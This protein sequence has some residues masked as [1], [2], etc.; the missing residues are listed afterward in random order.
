MQFCLDPVG[1][2]EGVISFSF[3]LL[4][5]FVTCLAWTELST[6]A[7]VIERVH[8]LAKGMPALPIF[9]DCAGCV[10]DDVKDVYFHNI[11]QKPS[12]GYN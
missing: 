10:I 9:S 4:A 6:S 11:H 5:K 1:T 2:P 7:A 3:Q 12:Y 8:L